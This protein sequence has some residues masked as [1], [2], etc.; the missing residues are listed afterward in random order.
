MLTFTA[1]VVGLMLVSWFGRVTAVKVKD[2]GDI[3]AVAVGLAGIGLV[4]W[5]F[6]F[7]M[8]PAVWGE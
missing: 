4:V 8:L 5:Q 3:I 6:F 1:I 7:R 2:G